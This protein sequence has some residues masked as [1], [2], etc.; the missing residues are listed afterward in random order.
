MSLDTSF[1]IVKGI[2][3][4]KCQF[5]NAVDISL[6]DIFKR[7]RLDRYFFFA[8]NQTIFIGDN[9]SCLQSDDTSDQIPFDIFD[10]MLS[11]DF[12]RFSC[13]DL[14]IVID[15]TIS[16]CQNISGADRSTLIDDFFCCQTNGI[17]RCDRSGILKL[18]SVDAR[19]SKCLDLTGIDDL[20]SAY[21]KRLR[22]LSFLILESCHQRDGKLNLFSCDLSLFSRVDFLFQADIF[23]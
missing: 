16:G 2:T 17:R 18:I 13:N 22:L 23:F 21:R 1:R 4:V 7:F 3:C 19:I 11:I 14:S 15:Q 9:L 10:L 12:Q 8:I 5:S 20:C 6:I